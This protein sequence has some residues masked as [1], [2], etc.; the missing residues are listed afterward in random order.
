MDLLRSDSEEEDLEGLT[1]HSEIIDCKTD[2]GNV[3]A[4]QLNATWPGASIQEGS[5]LSSL[6][7][8][9]SLSCDLMEDD[10]SSQDQPLF[11]QLGCSV[12]SRSSLYT[13]PVKLLPTCFTEIVEKLETNLDEYDPADLKITLDITCLNLPREVL[14]VSLERSPGLRTTSFCSASPAGSTRTNSESSP[15]YETQLSG[16]EAL[17]DR[18]QHLPRRQHNA[19]STLVDEIEWLLRDETATALLDDNIP[20]EHTLNLVA[21]H[22]SESSGRPSCST[23]KVPLHFV[24]PGERCSPKFLAELKKLEIERY[25]INEE[26]N[27]FYFTKNFDPKTAEK[28]CETENQGQK[29]ESAEETFHDESEVPEHREIE[30]R[31][32]RMD[33]GDPPGCLSEISSIGE[34][35]AGTDDGYEGDSSNSE[36]DCHW[37]TDLD[38]RRSRMPNFW[39]I[40][41][42]ENDYVYVYFHCR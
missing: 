2:H 32:S 28:D 11:L 20:T 4:N 13:A 24:F 18:I 26:G 5:K 21:R 3:K 39:L 9:Q 10:S 31:V 35:Q 30:S 40:L 6:A 38:K 17:Q 19:V 36:D 34:G 23:D 12:H 15:E 42:V 27:L 14:E 1:F 25:K 41:K 29:N 7:S 33:S 16:T 22:V 37:L 8:T